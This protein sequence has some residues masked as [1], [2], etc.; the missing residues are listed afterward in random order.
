[1]IFC[2]CS[3]S[4][5]IFFRTPRDIFALYVGVNVRELPQ[6]RQQYLPCC[7]N[8]LP[9]VKQFFSGYFLTRFSGMRLWKD[10]GKNI[11][12]YLADPR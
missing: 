2:L 10:E 11:E 5:A 3:G 6:A 9:Q 4:S 7:L 8:S 1:M 12:V